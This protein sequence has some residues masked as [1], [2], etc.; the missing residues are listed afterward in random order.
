MASTTNP[1]ASVP[2]FGASLEAGCLMKR[3]FR[4]FYIISFIVFIY[5]NIH[6]LL[7]TEQNPPNITSRS[8]LFNQDLSG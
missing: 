6:V 8:L 1:K 7:E 3:L 5:C 2:Y 4:L